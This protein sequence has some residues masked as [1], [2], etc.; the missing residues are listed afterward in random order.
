MSKTDQ[1][2]PLLE[3]NKFI[4]AVFL[5]FAM[6]LSPMVWSQDYQLSTKVDRTDITIDDTFNLSVTFNGKTSKRPDFSSLEKDFKVYS[7]GTSSHTS[8]INNS[9]ESVTEWKFT[10]EPRREGKLIIPSLSLGTNYSDAIEINVA[11]PEK[12]TTEA[13]S[14]IFLETKIEKSSAYVQEQVILT[15]RLYFSVGLSSLDEINIDLPNTVVEKLPETIFQ[16]R[17]NGKEYRVAEYSYAI[18]AQNSGVIEIP[19][20]TWRV[21]VQTASSQR[22]FFGRPVTRTQ[23][24]RFRS[25]S[26]KL[27]IKPKPDSFPAGAE[28]LPA[29]NLEI[30]S[31]W[32]SDDFRVGEPVTLNLLTQA[33]GLRAEQLPDFLNDESRGSIKYYVDQAQTNDEKSTSGFYAKRIESAAVVISEPGKVS[34]PGRRIPWWDVDEDKLKFAELPVKSVLVSGPVSSNTNDNLNDTAEAPDL[35]VLP[36]AGTSEIEDLRK[37]LARTQIYLVLSIFAGLSL[38]FLAFYLAQRNP[39]PAR[40]ITRAKHTPSLSRVLKSCTNDNALQVR[41]A[42]LAWAQE[43]WP[44]VK[45]L[46]ELSE[47]LPNTALK[48]QLHELDKTLY[49]NQKEQAQWNGKKLGESL[50]EAIKNTKKKTG[51]E[52]HLAELYPT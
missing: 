7:Q 4:I 27:T 32:S 10:L 12:S 3:T 25:D 30:K 20:L 5:F 45:T 18:F 13:V 28:W 9:V 52:Q 51:A 17:V 42:I 19:Q 49:G 36:G 48:E 23:I 26:I 34:I 39:R 38:A 37:Q 44:Q 41:G 11:P 22:D 21:G 29:K 50:Q 6:T 14:D 2:S 8:I 1:F 40:I 33:K 31:T 24:K 15:F 43:K 47:K 16:R 46:E 35:S